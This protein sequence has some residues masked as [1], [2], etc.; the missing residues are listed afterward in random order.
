MLPRVVIAL[1]VLGGVAHADDEIAWEAP[2]ECPAPE[3]V[4]TRVVEHLQRE[5]RPGEVAA[6]LRVTRDGNRW[7]VDMTVRSGDEE[8]GERSLDAATCGELAESAALILAM[9]IADVA[10]SAASIERETQPAAATT[11][12]RVDDSESPPDAEVDRRYGEGRVL[13]PDPPRELDLRL[14]AEVGGDIGS[15]PSLSPGLGGALEI[16]FGAWSLDLGAQRFATRD[17]LMP[18]G[19]GAGAHVGLTTF[20]ARVCVTG[21]DGR[22]RAAGCAGG[23]LTRTRAAGF[24]FTDDFPPSTTTGGGPQL[25]VVWAYRVAGPLSARLDVTATWHAVRATL[26]EAEE[27]M[28]VHD[29]NPVVWRGFTGVEVRWR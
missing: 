12:A 20:V 18:G 6:T 9:T 24:G 13:E 7:R 21:R 29:P 26:V 11:V 3:V 27:H 15:L 17:A 2:A 5:V 25:G 8:G 10:A 4:R 19:G 16:A 14:R 1:L 28:I 22:L 23:E